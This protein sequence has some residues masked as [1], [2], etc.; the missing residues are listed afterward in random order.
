MCECLTER[1]HIPYLH[2]QPLLPAPP[3]GWTVAW[4]P[5]RN[6]AKK[7]PRMSRVAARQER[8]LP[9]PLSHPLPD[10]RFLPT[11]SGLQQCQLPGKAPQKGTAAAGTA[12]AMGTGTT[13]PTS[14]SD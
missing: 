11:P 14:G 8:E 13:G 4:R 2:S 1:G 6:Q 7:P 9:G 10:T 12:V 5:D 3:V